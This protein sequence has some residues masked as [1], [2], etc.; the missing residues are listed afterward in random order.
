MAIPNVA[1]R[2]RPVVVV[3]PCWIEPLTEPEVA[4]T[5]RAGELFRNLFRGWRLR[6]RRE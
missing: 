5:E 4:V 6:S 1:L 3:Q 2:L